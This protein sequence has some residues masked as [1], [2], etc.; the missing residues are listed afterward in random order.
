MRFSF[1][2]FFSSGEGK[3]MRE[4]DGLFPFRMRISLR[5]GQ[6][7]PA[8][9]AS[10]LRSEEAQGVGDRDRPASGQKLEVMR[11]PTLRELELPKTSG[12]FAT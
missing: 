3:A 11:K 12:G 2:V 9:C 1:G 5:E 6:V 4:S 10:T 7:L 8:R